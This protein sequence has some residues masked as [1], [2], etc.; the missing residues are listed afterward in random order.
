MRIRGRILLAAA[1]AGAMCAPALAQQTGPVAT[2]WV[3]AATNTGMTAAGVKGMQAMGYNPQPGVDPATQAAQPPKAKRPGFGAMLGAAA[4]SMIPGAGLFTA[5]QQ[6][7]TAAAQAGDYQA[8]MT[9]GGK[10]IR[11]LALELGSTDRPSGAPQADHLI[12]PGMNMGQSLPLVTPEAAA[13]R[14]EHQGGM[15][16]G[17]Q[18]PKGKMMIYWGCGDHAAAPP[19]V[20]DFATLSAGQVPPFPTIEVKTPSG[21]SSSHSATFGSWP[22]AQDAK[23]VPD[24]ASL[25]GDH[26][27]HGDYSPDIHFRL[28][29]D[30][31]FMA[32]LTITGQDPTPGGGARVTWNAVPGATG[33]FLW[34]MTGVMQNGRPD[35]NTMIMW[36][37]SLKPSTFGALLDYIPPA[38]VRRL[39]AEQ[40]VLPP[41]ATEC[42]VPAEVRP[43]G[44]Y[45]ML[46]MIAYGD[47][48]NFADPPRPSSPK[49]AWNLKSV[50]KVRFKSTTSLMLGM[51]R[52]GGR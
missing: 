32:P 43:S 18:R 47:E 28:G 14:E 23:P 11:T 34:M 16:N 13:P 9:G 37:S 10:P 27:I 30:H 26:T 50:V 19:I 21:P 41:A 20:I 44:S 38:E 46:S 33:Y 51:P 24:T 35:E 49:A 8:M 36:S 2:Y 52:M 3:S 17:M 7:N 42:I 15:P 48:V 4:S 39:V 6:A 25:V 31:D 1:A 29:P 45:G 12:P 40:V 22:N 5:T